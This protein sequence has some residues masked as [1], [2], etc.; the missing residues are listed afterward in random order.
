MQSFGLLFIVVAA[1]LLLG[2]VGGAAFLLNSGRGQTLGGSGLRD[3]M[4]TGMPSAGGVSRRIREDGVDPLE[5]DVETLKKI[6]SRKELKTKSEDLDSKLFRAGYF[7]ADD[8]AGFNRFKL[9]VLLGAMVVCPLAMVAMGGTPMFVLL[10]LILGGLVGYAMP[11]SILERK[12]RAR[13]EEIM[14]YLPLV[15]EQVSI[16]V[17]SALDIGPCIAQ[18]VSMATERDS[19]NPVTEMFVNVEKLIRSGLNLEDALIEVSEATQMQE[20]KHAFMFLAQCSKHG[21][22]LSKQLQELADSVMTQRQLQVEAKIAS[23]P[24]KATL[25]LTMVLAGFFSLLFAG[26]AVKFITNFV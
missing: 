13:E 11:M 20:I 4:G 14:Y 24:V 18:I 12:I 26:L 3:L 2:L 19:H 22:E 10:G 5:L 17:S 15:I 7:S 23:L 9:M 21:G 25:P 8:R 6:T 16:G 1:V